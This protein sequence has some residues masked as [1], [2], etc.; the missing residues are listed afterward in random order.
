M[1]FFLILFILPLAL[2]YSD[3]CVYPEPAQCDWES[4][5]SCWGGEWDG[6]PLPDYCVSLK[7]DWNFGNDGEACWNTC[8]PSCY[9]EGQTFCDMGYDDN[10][11]YMGA[12]CAEGYGDCPATC[13]N[14][15][16]YNE[17]YC[18][19]GYD[20]NGCYLGNYCAY[21]YD[22]GDFQCPG[23][24][25]TNCDW[26]AGETWCEN[27]PDANGCWTGNWC[28]PEGTECPVICPEVEYPQCNWETEWSCWG[29]EDA[30]GCHLPDYCIP[31][32]SA[33]T[34]ND[35][36][37]CWNYCEAPGCYAEGSMV[38]DNGLDYNGCWMGNYCATPWNDCPAVCYESCGVDMAYCDLGTDDNGCWLGNYC[39]TGECAT[40]GATG[41]QITLD[42]FEKNPMKE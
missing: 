22:M 33:V 19:I 35:G 9:D 36:E 3:D 14:H 30:N 29:G 5:F 15:C 37:P 13:Y 34:G 25:A 40:G 4:E 20:D 8:W 12:Y 27:P 38:C 32:H 6:C 2:A 18:D 16:G 10:G 17:T 23:V 42:L 28:T 26:E 24:C 7:S 31:H 1:M 39:A 41:Y 21:G 11:C